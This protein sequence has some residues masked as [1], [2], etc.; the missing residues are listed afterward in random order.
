MHSNLYKYPSTPHLPFSQGL[1]PN[2]IPIDKT[3]KMHPDLAKVLL[4]INPKIIIEVIGMNNS[5]E[6]IEFARQVAEEQNNF[7]ALRFINNIGKPQT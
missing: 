2:G 1:Q 6:I 5:P 7:S 3:F 4:K